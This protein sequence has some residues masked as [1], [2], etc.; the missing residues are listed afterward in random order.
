MPLE[1]FLL[2]SVRTEIA[3][4]LAINDRWLVIDGES[5]KTDHLGVY[6]ISRRDDNY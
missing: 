4:R 1:L 5:E 3:F 6:P 2:D